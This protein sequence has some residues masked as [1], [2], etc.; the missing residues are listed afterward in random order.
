MRRAL[1]LFISNQGGR[2]RHAVRND[3]E[4][5]T[6]MGIR[7]KG[8]LERPIAETPIA[9]FD[10]ETTG[11]N[12]GADRVVEMSVVRIEP[13]REPKLLLDTLLN[14]NRKMAA[15]EIHGITEEDVMDAP[16]FEDVAGELLR[17]VYDCVL[18][19]YNIYFDIGFLHFEL[20]RVGF[21]ELPPYLCLMYM[22]PLLGLG[23][24]CCLEKAC[25]ELGF[26]HP[27]A[28]Q[29]AADVLSATKLWPIYL[30]AIR[31]RGLRLFGDLTTLKSYK[32]LQSLSLDPVMPPAAEKFPRAG[33]LKSRCEMAAP[34]VQPVTAGEEVAA[35]QINAMHSYWEALK[36]VLS[37]LNVSD[38]EMKYLAKMRKKLDLGKEEVRALHAKIFADLITQCVED[39]SLDDNECR[40]LHS[41]YQ[42]LEKLGWAPGH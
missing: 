5:E 35:S 7:D 4:G 38:E 10:F 14:P 19:S 40:T 2:N 28:H 6:N 29:A 15:S 32:F 41:L 3:L 26:Q 33:R 8:V 27:N 25:E 16:K 17:S 42:C 1:G 34:T 13:G 21:R 22:R 23:R 9:V 30:Q 37:D 39:R 11:L 31:Q 18:A 12:A 20:G 24:R 36:T